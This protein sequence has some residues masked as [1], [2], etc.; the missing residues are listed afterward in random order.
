MLKRI[1]KSAV[2]AALSLVLLLSVAGLSYA[3]APVRMTLGEKALSVTPILSQDGT[4]YAPY[5]TLF[6]ALGATASYNEAA[7]TITAVSGDTQVVIPL[8]SSDIIVTIGGSDFEM[9]SGAPPI[10][11]MSSGTVYVPVRAVCRALGYAVTWD[12]GSRTIALQTLDE[13]IGKSGATYTVVDSFLAYSRSFNEKAHAL[14]GS[15]DMTLDT[16]GLSGYGYGDQEASPAPLKISGTADGLFDKGGEEM[17]LNLKTN[18]AEYA[19]LYSEDEALSDEEQ[20]LVELLSDIDIDL[21]VNAET[22]FIYLR[23][24]LLTLLGG[25]PADAWVSIGTEELGLGTD[26]SDIIG[27]S[28]YSGFNL[29]FLNQNATSFKEY[30]KSILRLQLIVSDG[31]VGESLKQINALISDQAMTRDGDTYTVMMT[32][33]SGEDDWYSESIALE[34]TFDLS[35]GAFQG[36]AATFVTESSY[37]FY[38]YYDYEDDEYYFYSSTSKVELSFSYTAAGHGWLKLTTSE[39]GVTMLALNMDFTYSETNETP[40]REPAPGSTVISFED[41]LDDM[42]PDNDF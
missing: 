22:G 18:V 10:V 19:A 16:G 40:A 17:S 14:S 23:S 7:R 11:N 8:D 24:P 12:G 25:V 15:F 33:S 28:Y 4:T 30:L 41:L 31:D 29:S 26:I 2:T 21:I 6:K 3:A 34:L 42:I 39:D 36:V 35:G 37:E 27:S 5:N 1:L 9:Y 32:D 20:M 13:L 38:D